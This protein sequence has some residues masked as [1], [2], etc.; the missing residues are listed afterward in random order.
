MPPSLSDNKNQIVDSGAVEPLVALAKQSPPAVQH[1]AA[2]L[3][4]NL[5]VGYEETI[6]K[7]ISQKGG[8]EIIRRPQAGSISFATH[9]V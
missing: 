2:A 8:G 5:A 7:L 9:N 1:Q 3:L 4:R 6:G